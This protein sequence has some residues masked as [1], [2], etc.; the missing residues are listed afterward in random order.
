MIADWIEKHCPREIKSQRTL[1]FRALQQKFKRTEEGWKRD[2]PKPLEILVAI[3]FHKRLYQP[4]SA[5][6]LYELI[7]EDCP[8]VA[9]ATR[10]LKSSSRYKPYKGAPGLLWQVEE[11][12][13]EEIELEAKISLGESQAN[14]PGIPFPELIDMAL[15]DGPNTSEAIYER[16]RRRYPFHAKSRRLIGLA[17]GRHDLE[18]VGDVYYPSKKRKRTPQDFAKAKR[19][20]QNVNGNYLS[21]FDTSVN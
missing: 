9:A 16:I 4:S 1:I 13:K 6:A 8:N 10:H 2:S 12:L 5:E 14:D 21:L 3:A 20:R 15:E 19:T 17:I 7:K 18:K 11:E